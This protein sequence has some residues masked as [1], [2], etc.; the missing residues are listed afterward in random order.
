[1]NQAE[2]EAYLRDYSILKNSGKPFFPYIV[3]KDAAMAVIVMIVNAIRWS[4]SAFR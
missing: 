1:M 3:A 2:K 4:A